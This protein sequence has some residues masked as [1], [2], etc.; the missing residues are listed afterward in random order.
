MQVNEKFS[1]KLLTLSATKQ[2]LLERKLAQ[3]RTQSEDMDGASLDSTVRMTITQRP[4]EV[5]HQAPLSF[6]QQRIWFLQQLEPESGFYN[7]PIALSIRGKLSIKAL[8][9]A[10]REVTRRHEVMRSTFPMVDG[11]AVQLLHPLLEETWTIPIQDLSAYSA[12]QQVAE[13]QYIAA[14]EMKRP[15]QLADQLPWRTMLLR[16]NEEEHVSLTIM[17]HIITDGWS[18]EVFIREVSM[19]YASFSSGLKL[20]LPEPVIQYADYTHWQQQWIKEKIL[21]TQLPYWKEC[22]SGLLPTLELPIDHPRPAIQ[23]YTGS[24][25]PVVIPTDLMQR[26][27]ALSQQERVTPFM[28]LLAAFNILLYRYSGQ[29]DIIIGSPIAG[30]T[31]HEL[32]GLMGCF[33]NTLP[34]RTDLRDN[35]SFLELLQ[36]EREITLAAYSHQDLPF[37]KLVEELQLERDQSRNP[38]FQVLFVLQNMPTATQQLGE[39]TI[40]PYDVEISTAK[41]DLSLSLQEAAQGFKGFIEYNTDLFDQ[42]TIERMR[43]HF[44]HIL[45]TLVADPT[46]HIADFMLLSESERKQVTQWNSTEKH[47]AAETLQ[48]AFEVQVELTPDADAIHFGRNKLTYNELNQRAN[49]LAHYLR[50]LEVG[51]GTL[52]GIC[53]ERSLELVISLFGILKAG[54]AYVPI[55]PSYPKERIAYIMQDAHVPVLLTQDR[56]KAHLPASEAHIIIEKSDG[57]KIMQMSTDNPLPVASMDDLAYV[58][59]T[60]GSTGRPKGAMNTH[61]GINNRLQWMQDAYQLEANERVLQKTPFSFDV[62]VWEFFWPLLYGAQLVLAKPDGHRD[63]EYLAKVI[64]EQ[65]ITTIHFV[66]SMLR[67]FLDTPGVEACTSLQRVICSG[68]ALPYELQQAFF[69]CYPHTALYNLYGPTEAAIDVTAWKC[70]RTSSEQVVP[71]GYPIANTQIY[72]LDA[73]QQ[74]VPAGIPGE[75]Y[76]GG[77]GVASGY[78]NQPELTRERFIAD[79]FSSTENARL[80]KTGDRARYLPDGA[81]VYL[82]RND[83]QV[84]LRGMRIEP[85]E[86]EAALL[87]HPAVQQCVV[88]AREDTPGDQRLVAYSIAQP[89]TTVTANELRS[90]TKELLPDVMIPSAFVQLEAFPLQPNGKLDR[91]ALP[92]TKT[93]EVIE[94]PMP[95]HQAPRTPLEQQLMEIWAQILDVPSVGITENFFEIGGHSLLVAQVLTRVRETIGVDLPLRMMFLSPTI[96]RLA[97]AIERVQQRT[98]ELRQRTSVQAVG[99]EAY[100]TKRSAISAN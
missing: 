91:R 45:E 15:F 49:Q 95:S 30:R 87:K 93:M 44:L 82:G 27:Q 68:E 46:Q 83:D 66:P 97:E 85:G 38:L 19:L 89:G 48:L 29:E 40:T 20:P 33:V 5:Y 9:Q 31:Y 53:M 73:H 4:Q 25:L 79:P 71:I 50:Q 32:E 96:E 36:R 74:L 99:R 14:Q 37:E 23:T 70:Q 100:R 28:S 86:I 65:Q 94:E 98:S 63:T 21:D 51:P 6:A 22:M 90:H 72:L 17:H 58:I 54:A 13:V 64:Q 34:L 55:D 57:Q 26:L 76:I 24:R 12:D 80:Y 18:M 75:L 78:L 43:N 41:F 47:Y 35:P 39:L 62:S 77:T 69:K 2:A 3:L 1:E 61:R 11:Q 81:I 59:Y 7:E 92:A 42:T 10:I 60:S 88:I 67:A 52:I 56:L 16:L 84:K 8:S